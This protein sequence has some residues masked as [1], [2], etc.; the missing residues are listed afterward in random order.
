MHLQRFDIVDLQ[1]PFLSH[2]FI[3]QRG[4]NREGGSLPVFLGKA[5]WHFM[6]IQVSGTPVPLWTHACLCWVQEVIDLEPL[7]CHNV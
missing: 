5:L 3:L 6:I 2:Q 7:V 1:L 4:S